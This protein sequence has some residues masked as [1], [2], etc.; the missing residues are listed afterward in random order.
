M[1]VE[2]RNVGRNTTTPGFGLQGM[3]ERV[4]LLGGQFDLQTEIAQG[5]RIHITLPL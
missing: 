2:G 5:T 1:P 3:I 4:Q